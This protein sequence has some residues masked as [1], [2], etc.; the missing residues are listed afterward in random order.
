MK[1]GIFSSNDKWI[2]NFDMFEINNTA[3]TFLQLAQSFLFYSSPS[4]SSSFSSPS[5][6]PRALF[7]SLCIQQRANVVRMPTKVRLQY[8][9]AQ[10]TITIAAPFDEKQQRR[11]LVCSSSPL[12]LGRG[13]KNGIRRRA[14]ARLNYCCRDCC[15]CCCCRWCCCLQSK[16]IYSCP[17]YQMMMMMKAMALLQVVMFLLMRRKKTSVKNKKWAWPTR[18]F[19]MGNMKGVVDEW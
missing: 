1:K 9:L 17:Y 15:C 16:S 6:P 8:A 11:F 5:P 14:Y 19:R 7:L 18:F 4:S 12:L 2:D 13:E 3:R 10:S